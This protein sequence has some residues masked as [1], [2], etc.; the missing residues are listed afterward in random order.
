MGFAQFAPKAYFSRVWGVT[1]GTREKVGPNLIQHM[2]TILGPG[3]VT[4]ACFDWSF[5]SMLAGAVSDPYPQGCQQWIWA[6]TPENQEGGSWPLWYIES[7]NHM[8]HGPCIHEYFSDREICQTCL[9]D[10]W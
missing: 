3:Y 5:L 9:A 6:Q 10:F 1:V 7:W 8:A 2:L 4:K